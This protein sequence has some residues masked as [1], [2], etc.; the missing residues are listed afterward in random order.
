MNKDIIAKIKK[1]IVYKCPYCNA[2]YS[3]EKAAID[4]LNKH[5]VVFEIFSLKSS[6]GCWGERECYYQSTNGLYKDYREALQ[7]KDEDD[8]IHIRVLN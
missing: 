6:V 8:E 7:H 4:C 2:S 5:N 1:E 3:T